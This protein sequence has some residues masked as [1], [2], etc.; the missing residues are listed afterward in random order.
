MLSPPPPPSPAG[1]QTISI[2]SL[3]AALAKL[4]ATFSA[5]DLITAIREVGV[6]KRAERRAVMCERKWPAAAA[7]PLSFNL[8]NM[9]VALQRPEQSSRS[10]IITRSY[11]VQDPPR[12]EEVD[13]RANERR[14]PL[15][16]L[17][18]QTS[19][20][21]R[22]P[23]PFALSWL[24]LFPYTDLDRLPFM[25]ATRIV[26]S[27]AEDQ[28]ANPPQQVFKN[29]WCLWDT[30]AQVSSIAT[31]LVLPSVRNNRERGSAIMDI[32]CARLCL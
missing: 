10:E 17:A 29:A 24:G 16:E 6:A 27:N 2:H 1:L 4:G 14:R 5:E 11:F 7:C 18:E 28:T 20:D 32:T 26:I 30:G 3:E 21:G 13:P 23:N 19:P 8:F 15:I 22:A 9:L 25:E 12:P 31:H